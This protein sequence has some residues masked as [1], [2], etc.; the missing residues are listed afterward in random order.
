MPLEVLSRHL[1]QETIE[2][3]K[4]SP[5]YAQS[6]D[7]ITFTLENRAKQVENIENCVEKIDRSFKEFA[8][9][10]VRNETAIDKIDINAKTQ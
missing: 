4:E 8:K 2:A 6:S 7:A 1:P 5:H 9:K 3:T 10:M